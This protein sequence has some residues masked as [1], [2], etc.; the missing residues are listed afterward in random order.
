M[1]TPKWKKEAKLLAKGARKFVHYKRDRLTEERV[2][3]IEA[4]REDL[5]KAAKA[6]E[7]EKVAEAS[8]QLRATCENAL[9]YEKP[10]GWLEENVEVMFVA[11]VIALGLRAY[12]LQPFRIP[13]GSMQP[14][15]N[16]IVGTPL[17]KEEWPGLPTRLWER[18][19]KGRTYVHAVNERDR[20]LLVNADGVPRLEDAQ[21]LHF[22]SRSKL[23]FADG[24]P[25]TLPAPRSQVLELGLQQVLR[26]ALSGNG[27][28]IKAGQVLFEGTVDAG[29]LVLVDKVSYH[30]RKPSRGEVFV[31]DTIGIRGIHERSGEQAEGTHY[32]KRLA[33]VPGDTL[34]IEPPNLLIDGKIAQEPELVRV[35]EASGIY[36]ENPQGYVLADPRESQGLLNAGRTPVR[37][38][39]SRS[40]DRLELAEDARPGQRE[41]AALG[42]NTDSSLDSRYWGPVKEFNLVGPAL[43]SL[44]PITTGHWGFID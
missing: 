33:G 43:F 6:G 14:T 9:P 36:S 24:R 37:Q 32:I 25:M 12:Y 10:Q 44:W 11:I 18:V 22:F 40:T 20:R 23:Y 1:F 3:E 38:Y 7:R 26:Q 39:L 34:S 41:Y 8:K 27:G 42:D 19:T 28:V 16:G 5:L 30:F 13:T 21:V 15:L 17:P 31:F 35:M 2:A 4:R 29:D